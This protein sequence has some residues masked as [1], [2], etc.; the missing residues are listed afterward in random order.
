MPR[1]AGDD[2]LWLSLD[3]LLRPPF[4]QIG[5][6]PLGRAADVVEIHRVRSHTGKFRRLIVA[7]FAALSFGNNLANR[8][9]AEAAGTES[10]RAKEAVVQFRPLLRVRQF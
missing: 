10:E 5:H 8:P 3:L 2:D 1:I 7:R 6:E 9:S 4:P